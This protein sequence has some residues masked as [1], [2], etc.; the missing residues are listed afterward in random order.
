MNDE[1]TEK[2]AVKVLDDISRG[3]KPSYGLIAN[4]ITDLVYENRSLR[5][6]LSGFLVKQDAPPGGDLDEGGYV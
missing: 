4:V 2:L 1:L 6:D 3:I 5:H